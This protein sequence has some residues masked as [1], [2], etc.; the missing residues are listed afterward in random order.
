MGGWVGGLEGA[1][2]GGG[3]GGVVWWNGWLVWI[4]QISVYLAPHATMHG[5]LHAR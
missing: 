1:R 4:V 2:G 5:K 3:G